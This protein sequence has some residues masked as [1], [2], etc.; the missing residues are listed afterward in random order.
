[1]RRE[2][3]ALVGES[4][5]P[6]GY[7]AT[8]VTILGVAALVAYLLDSFGVNAAYAVVFGVLLAMIAL[9]TY[10]LTLE[11][12]RGAEATK[13]RADF[14]ETV[15]KE[16][17]DAMEAR[18]SELR[19][20][21]STERDQL[22]VELA[23]TV[24]RARVLESERDSAR[25]AAEAERSSTERAKIAPAMDPYYRFEPHTFHAD[26]HWAGVRNQ[27]LGPAEN[28]SLSLDFRSTSERWSATSKPYVAVL[29]AGGKFEFELNGSLF[30]RRPTQMDV[31]VTYD[32][33]TGAHRS[34]GVTVSF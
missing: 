9:A 18:V 21:L 12:R 32:D 20:T 7:L 27:G 17:A 33:L 2:F 25:R 4:E 3:A 11:L 30:S 13:S 8:I 10:Y 31:T 14:Q 29:V 22:K 24:D 15:R 34:K 6:L 16:L 28:V 23:A 26:R 1:M 19:K 5:R